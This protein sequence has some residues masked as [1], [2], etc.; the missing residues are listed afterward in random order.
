M[1]IKQTQQAI[2]FYELAIENA[3]T[4]VKFQVEQDEKYQNFKKKYQKVATTLFYQNGMNFTFYNFED[5]I[6]KGY[7][8]IEDGEVIFSEHSSDF[9]GIE[10]V[11][12]E[13][14]SI[15]GKFYE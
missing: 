11:A 1:I 4:Q 2:K 9:T 6:K 5:D 10:D 8:E 7:F 13:L 15:V 3:Q 12:E 14:L